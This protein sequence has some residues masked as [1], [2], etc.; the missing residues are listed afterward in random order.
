MGRERMSET[1]ATG[2]FADAGGAHGF[3]KRNLQNAFRDMMPL[4]L[5]T[6]RILRE[7][8]GCKHV[9]PRPFPICIGIF[10]LQSER[11]IDIAEAVGKVLLML[12]LDF[13]KMALQRL[14]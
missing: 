9:L 6:P 8:R 1:V 5:S 3:L 12:R 14:S 10:P 7:A 13:Q 11:K 4:F 2:W